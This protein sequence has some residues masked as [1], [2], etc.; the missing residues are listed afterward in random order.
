MTADEPIIRAGPGGEVTDRISAYAKPGS[1][2]SA[3]L[4]TDFDPATENVEVV[5]SGGNTTEEG[6]LPAGPSYDLRGRVTVSETGDGGSS[7]QVDGHEYRIWK[8][9]QA[10]IPASCTRRNRVLKLG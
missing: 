6:D 3:T 10:W 7:V 8:V 9:K 1:M 5:L 2:L 4:V